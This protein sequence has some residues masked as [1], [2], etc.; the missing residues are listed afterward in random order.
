MPL[1]R[2]A[3][4]VP[5]AAPMSP[6]PEHILQFFAYA[7]LPPMLQVVSKPFG[8]LAE[9]IVETLPRNPE[10]TQ[11]PRGEGRGR[12]RTGGEVS[13]ARQQSERAPTRERHPRARCPVCD[14]P[15]VPADQ[16]G[17]TWGPDC[18]CQGAA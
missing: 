6:P 12:P 14:L 1:S 16:S 7:H 4:D 3:A 9:H 10:R 17:T 13:R 11:A 18:A 8:E 15:H 2:T 5:F